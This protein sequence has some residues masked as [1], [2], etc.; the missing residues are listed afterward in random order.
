M[1]DFRTC[2]LLCA[3]SFS[4]AC[5]QSSKG[6]AL[7]DVTDVVDAQRVHDLSPDS[8]VKSDVKDIG[9]GPDDVG[10]DTDLGRESDAA[11]RMQNREV[12]IVDFETSVGSFAVEV[13]R[14]WAPIGADHFRE[15]VELGFYDDQRFFRVV[16]GFIAQ[17]GINGTPNVDAM[18]SSKPILD[19]PVIEQNSRGTLVFAATNAANSRTSQLFINFGNNSNL[20]GL[21]FAPFAKIIS[22]IEVADM[23]NDEYGEEPSQI[24]IKTRGNLYLDNNFPNLTKIISVKIR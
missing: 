1:N 22:G 23:I 9:Q 14:A 7:T 12:Y 16:P 2:L 24:Q 11:D 10:Q 8:G 4:L 6:G 13:H 18:W 20:D 5:S 3:L 21:G 19:D 17:F 15:L